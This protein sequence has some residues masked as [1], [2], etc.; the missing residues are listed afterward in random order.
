MAEIELI[1][2][3]IKEL[4][5]IYKTYVEVS[6]KKKELKQEKMELDLKRVLT[7]ELPK[8]IDEVADYLMRQSNTHASSSEEDEN[9]YEEGVRRLRR[10]QTMSKFAYALLSSSSSSLSQTGSSITSLSSSTESVDTEIDST[11]LEE[12]YILL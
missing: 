1:V 3:L 9:I 5:S 4:H 8:T 6:T 10:T 7:E 2:F 11:E 12:E